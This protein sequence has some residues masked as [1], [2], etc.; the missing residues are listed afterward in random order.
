MKTCCQTREVYVTL[1]DVR[2][3]EVHVGRPDFVQFSAPADATYLDQDDDPMWRDHVFR[4]DGS[5]RVLQ[6][7]PEGDC[8]FLGSHGCTL[9]LEVRPLVCRLYPFEYTA[10]GIQH[11]LATGCPLELLPAGQGLVQALDMNIDAARR[12]HRQLYEEI[13]LEKTEVECLACE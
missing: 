3:I 4:H 8:T 6:R 9:P 2:R 10:E 1:G 12:W 13:L 11:E 7:R 5:R